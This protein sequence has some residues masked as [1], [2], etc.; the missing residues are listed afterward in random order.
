MFLYF[1]K[2]LPYISVFA[3]QKQIYPITST[4]QLPGIHKALTRVVSKI[5]QAN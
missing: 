2:S 3:L 4:K 1:C 5:L